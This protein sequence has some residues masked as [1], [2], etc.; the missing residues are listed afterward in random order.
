VGIG[1][2]LTF[3]LVTPP[4]GSFAIPGDEW[5][6]GL[7]ALTIGAGVVV[8]VWLVGRSQR[9]AERTRSSAESLQEL[10]ASLSAAA[11]PSQVAN[12]LIATV[13]A[14][15]GASGGSLALIEGSELVI[16]DPA[17]APRQA[18]PPGLQLP[19]AARAILA[20]AARD[21]MAVYVNTREEFEERY[22]EG[23]LLAPASA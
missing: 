8:L 1:W 15:L 18:L 5:A 4:H 11:E 6:R 20:T 23:A 17:G 9:T 12:A 14:M 3:A 10:A 2:P 13:P 16:V 7:V 21:G 22:P 19:L